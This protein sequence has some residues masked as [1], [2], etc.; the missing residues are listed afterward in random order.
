MA[1]A[2]VAALLRLNTSEFMA[3]LGEAEGAM[4]KVAKGGGS[5][6]EQAGKVSGI[7]AASIAGGAL[8]V[9]IAAVDM[10]SKYDDAHVSMV[11]SAKAAGTSFDALKPQIDATSS[12]MEKFGYTNAQTEEAVG[13]LLTSQGKSA[14]IMKDMGLAANIAAA[15]HIDLQTAIGLVEKAANGQSKPL[16]AMGIDL[17]VAAGGA[18]ATAKAHDAL[19]K[20]QQK[21]N[22]DMAAGADRAEAGSKANNKLGA[23]VLSLEGAHKKLAD[24][25]SAGGQI[26]DALSDRFGGQA[27]TA[28]DTMAGRMKAMKANG[29]DLLKTLG[30]KLIPVIDGLVKIIQKAVTWLEKHK[31]VAIA[32]AIVIGGVLATAF[33]VWAV[34]LFM[35][36]GALSPIVVPMMI[37]I[38]VIAL[39]VLGVMELIK[40]WGTIVKFFGKVFDDVKKI[41]TEAV[42][43][44]VG[45]F[46]RLPGQIVSTLGDIVG[47][48][49]GALKTAGVWVW[50][51]GILPVITFF[52]SLPG[53]A[54]T[55]IG[56]IIGTVFKD[57]IKISEWFVTN[58]E[59]PV[60][61]WFAA[62]PGK[63]FTAI[64]DILRTIFKDFIKISEWFV[65]NVEIP[66]IQ[67]FTAL[68]GK[69]FTA[70]GNLLGTI[71]KDALKIFNWFE[72]NV[73]APVHNWFAALPGKAFTA[74]GN[75]LGTI[76]AGALAIGT[77]L[78]NNVLQ[79]AISWF[80]SLPGKIVSSVG[81]IA[82]KIWD[83][84]F[85]GG[86][87]ST[88]PP[89][90]GH[91]SGGSV[92]GGM[93]TIIGENGP[94]LFTPS[95]SGYI[96]SNNNLGG[97]N[98]GGSTQ[99]NL[100]IDGKT[101]A[102]LMLPSLQTT[103]LQAQRSSSV[104]IFGSAA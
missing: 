61:K 96:T 75:L 89:P 49:F 103:V 36:D 33:T 12:Q 94:E 54:F 6:F 57:F 72:D 46:T 28:A 50:Q 81:N 44:V 59:I 29:E 58:V 64:G 45:F 67:W 21:V 93:P 73:A 9:G 26:I 98:G 43:A 74:L 76:F 56:D 24:T 95:S 79:P 8:A 40:H 77:W 85:G 3:K 69:A 88:P 63:A 20:A 14:P 78:E 66:V 35:V 101:F 27:S 62:L 15:K 84:I 90:K 102:T 65:T 39:M 41:F 18:K 70:L 55:A 37:I 97:G 34:S 51:N 25:Q 83:G 16:K 104:N 1:L 17:N 87:S 2:E 52:T 22:D 71:F 82:G 99:V 23:D 91:A 68:P 38:G 42:D 5:S 86:G 30:E 47:T 100:Q 32:L 60:I 31:D 53:K 4:H 80:T 19:S 10:A 48:V 92:T 13:S 7:A 11:A